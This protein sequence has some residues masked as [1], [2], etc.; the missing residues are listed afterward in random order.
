MGGC[1]ICHT[2]GENIA[3]PGEPKAMVHAIVGMMWE[4]S[5]HAYVYSPRP[6]IGKEPDVCSS[7]FLPH[8]K[9]LC[10]DAEE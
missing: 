6:K 7:C 5:Y 3:K 2:P 9:C 4:P 8:S 1:L 10:H